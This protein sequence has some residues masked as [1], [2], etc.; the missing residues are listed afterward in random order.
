MRTQVLGSRILAEGWTTLSRVTLRLPDG[1]KIERNV[2]H[3]GDAAAVLPYDPLRRTLML[4]KMPTRAPVVLAGS[5]DILEIAAGQIDAELPE[6]CARREAEEELGLRLGE[7]EYLG[8][9][10]AMPALSTERMHLFLAPYSPQDRVGPGGGAAGE[11]E[12]I[13]VVEMPIAQAWSAAMTGGLPDMKSLLALHA[14]R[15]RRP[16]LFDA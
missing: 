7:L 10:W 2:E 16:E 8:S 5:D 13:T 4:V 3:H 11:D 1:S 12:H 14:L 15:T 6:A 9:C